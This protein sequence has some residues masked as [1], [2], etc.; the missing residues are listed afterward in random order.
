MTASQ[1]RRRP[2]EEIVHRL[3]RP[4]GHSAGCAPAYPGR[5]ALAWLTLVVGETIASLDGV[6]YLVQDARELLRIDIIVLAIILYAI[7]G[8]LSDLITRLIER[9][10]LRWH[11]NYADK[12]KA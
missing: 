9:R 3:E 11:P 2:I 6:G 10:L 8:W 12:V 5:H 1:V 4:D 7:A